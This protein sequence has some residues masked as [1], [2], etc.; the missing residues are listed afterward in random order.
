L[1]EIAVKKLILQIYTESTKFSKCI[2]IAQRIFCDRSISAVLE[3]C[4][5]LVWGIK[6]A[7]IF[8]GSSNTHILTVG[9]LLITFLV[10]SLFE[11]FEIKKRA[12]QEHID[13]VKT[14]P[15]A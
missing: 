13:L 1:V 5:N 14:Y 10:F 4:I 3:R 2:K 8:A 6:K 15:V 11:A 7:F 9:T 12:G